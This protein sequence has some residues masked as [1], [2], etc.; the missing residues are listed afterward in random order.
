MGT[1][2]PTENGGNKSMPELN[3]IYKGDCLEIM[4]QWPDACADLV[5]TDPPYG[6]SYRTSRRSDSDPLAKDIANDSGDW[7]PFAQAWLSEVE[8]LLKPDSHFYAFGSFVTQPTFQPM[9]AKQL[10]FKNV[11]VWDKMNWSVGDLEGDY[12][13][14]YEL[15]YFAHKGRRLLSGEKRYGNLLRASRGSGAEYEH[16]TQKPEEIIARL[17]ECSSKE[18]EVVLDP[19]LGSGTTALVAE[20]MGR[21]WI[22][23]E[24]EPQYHGV[25]EARLDAERSQGKLF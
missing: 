13:R 7:V 4:R 3:R 9:I 10:T 17:V 1:P 6:V 21:R 19:F 14:Q 11:L 15:I 5:V 20:K 2:P 16:P 22:G 8:R 25:I 12:G 24:I 23:C 18:G